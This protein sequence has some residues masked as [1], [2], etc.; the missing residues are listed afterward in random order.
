MHLKS[1]GGQIFHIFR[2]ADS[3]QV[4]FDLSTT[5]TSLTHVESTNLLEKLER[6]WLVLSF[7]SFNMEDTK[8]IEG[9][10]GVARSC[11]KN[12]DWKIETSHLFNV[13]KDFLIQSHKANAV[14][15]PL[16]VSNSAWEF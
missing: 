3:D 15:K 6:T 13:K 4:Y 14:W 12:L 1:Q 11:K 5:Q 10:V 2:V 8:W 7:Q 16:L 9:G